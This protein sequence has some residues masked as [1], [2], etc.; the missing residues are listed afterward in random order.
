[1]HLRHHDAKKATHDEKE[2][3]NEHVGH[4]GISLIFPLILWG[5]ITVVAGAVSA[6]FLLRYSQQ[7]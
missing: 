7:T 1:M 4:T 3:S 5:A 2:P 6:V